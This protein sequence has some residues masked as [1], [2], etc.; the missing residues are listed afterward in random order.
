MQ[1]GNHY[2]TG[3]RCGFC[4]LGEKKS[5]RWSKVAKVESMLCHSPGF[6]AQNSVQSG[7]CCYA[8]LVLLWIAVIK[9][10]GLLVGRT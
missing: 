8:V 2:P 6:A 7:I 4:A 3:G 1:G 10:D 5:S 9:T